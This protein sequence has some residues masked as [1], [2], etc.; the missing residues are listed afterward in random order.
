LQPASGDATDTTTTNKTNESRHARTRGDEEDEARRASERMQISLP[1][2]CLFVLTPLL[3]FKIV[4][5]KF[6]D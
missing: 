1:R 6:I 4:S 5:L 3:S 2:A